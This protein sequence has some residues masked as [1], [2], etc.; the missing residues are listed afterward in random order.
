M[1]IGVRDTITRYFDV[2]LNKEGIVNTL[3]GLANNREWSSLDITILM[4]K[5]SSLN[6]GNQLQSAGYTNVRWVDL[7]I[8]RTN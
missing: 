7:T 6:K 1:L 3:N 5:K 2:S 8:Q 4:G